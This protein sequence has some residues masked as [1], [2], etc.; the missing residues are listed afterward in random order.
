MELER[1][2]R[3]TSVSPPPVT[4]RSSPEG[5]LRRRWTDIFDAEFAA[6]LTGQVDQSLA[7]AGSSGAAVA[8]LTAPYYR[9]A[10]RPDGGHWPENDPL[11][12][13]RFNDIVREVAARHP[14]V[15]LV[16]LGRRTNPSGRFTATIDGIRMRQ[17]GVHYTVQAC[18][19]F[20][21]WL[22]PQAPPDR[23]RHLRLT[24]LTVRG[25]PS[26]VM[27]DGRKVRPEL[28]LVHGETVGGVDA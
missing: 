2:A 26:T 5:Q 8:V 19:W 7:V 3:S 21:P 13:D 25:G 10:E 17:D 20:A 27:S 23:R 12:V 18:G 6:Y 22:V 4:G 28:E 1:W 15:L 16:D 11:R 24:S 9:G 14:E